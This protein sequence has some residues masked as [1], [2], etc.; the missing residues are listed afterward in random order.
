MEA[1]YC[2]NLAEWTGISEPEVPAILAVVFADMVNSVVLHNNLGGEEMDK[3]RDA[4]FAHARSLSEENDGFVVKTTGDALLVIFRSAIC[5]LDYALA[6]RRNTGHRL[7][8][9]HAGIDVGP[10]LLK[11]NDVFGRAVDFAARLEGKAGEDEILVSSAVK[12]HIQ[13]FRANRHKGLRWNNRTCDF[14][15]FGECTVWSVQE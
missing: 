5:A 6:V 11:R 13:E 14:K 4:Y 3:V 10:V 9:I 7:V 8:S 12:S 1:S 15:G 2:L